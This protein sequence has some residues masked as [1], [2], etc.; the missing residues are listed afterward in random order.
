[1]AR[2]GASAKVRGWERVGMAPKK[3]KT[4]MAIKKPQPAKS[5]SVVDFMKALATGGDDDAA[6]SSTMRKPA[7]TALALKKPAASGYACMR[8][9]VSYVPAF[10]N[11]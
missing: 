11:T 2:V 6:S 9:Y 1:M 5:G 7:S 8:A 10:A 3:A 4:A